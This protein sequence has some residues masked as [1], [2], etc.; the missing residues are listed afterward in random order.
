MAQ[1]LGVMPIYGI[2]KPS[3]NQLKFKWV[4]LRVAYSVWVAF[5]VTFLII[6]TIIWA[7]FQRVTMSVVGKSLKR[8]AFTGS[9]R[10]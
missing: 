8:A 7:A 6:C 2:F 9:P 10:Q 5:T 3:A 4:S 1:C